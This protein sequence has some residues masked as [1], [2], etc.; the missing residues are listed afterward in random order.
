[1]RTCA[2]CGEAFGKRPNEKPHRFNRRK[3]CS[4]SCH[5][6]LLRQ[7]VPDTR[8]KGVAANEHSKRAR[9]QRKYPLDGVR[10]EE[11]GCDRPAT[12]RHHKN[13]DPGD[14]RR[15]NLELLCR[16]H[17]RGRHARPEGPCSNCGRP[18]P[19]GKRRQG[20]CPACAAYLYRT[21]R[22]RPWKSDGRV[23]GAARRGERPEMQRAPAPCS[24]CGALSKPRWK[25]RCRRCYDYWRYHGRQ[26]ERP[27][28]KTA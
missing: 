5:K 23:E 15:A 21:G 9:A 6:A 7:Q 10:C 17:H 16:R 14:N 20:R 13:E 11:P 25:A 8:Y 26:Q 24:N 27:V 12:D 4:S 22:E 28:S 3:T 1:M 19:V 2:V 18:L